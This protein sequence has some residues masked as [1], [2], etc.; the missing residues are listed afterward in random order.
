MLADEI[1]GCTGCGICVSECEFLKRHGTPLAMCRSYDPEDPKKNAICFECS[2]C[3]L[4]SAVCPEGCYPQALFL[5]MRREAV[6]RGHGVFPGHKR[7]LGYERT[8]LSRRFSWY[9]LP[10][11][12]TT[13]FFP[14]C[15]LPGTRPDATMAVYEKLKGAIPALGLVMDCCTKPSHDLGRQRYFSEMFGEMV[16]WLEANGIQ[17]ILVACPNC[18][19][20]FSEYARQFQ[21]ETIYEELAG[22]MPDSVVG[23][24]ATPVTIHDP[25]VMRFACAPQEAVRELVSGSGYVT[26][27]MPHARITTLCCGEGGTVAAL[28]P[29]LAESWGERRAGEAANRQVVT[30]CAGC[31]NFLGKRLK[32]SHVLDLICATPK[33]SSGPMT[34]FNRLR[35]KSRFRKIVPAAITRE[36]T[37]SSG[38]G[39]GVLW[40]LLILAA[41]LVILF[42]LRIMVCG[43]AEHAPK[44]PVT[45]SGK[46]K[47][48]LFAKN[49]AT[50]A[51]VTGGAGGTLIYREST[52]AFT[53]HATGL[54]PRAAYA[55]IR[56]ADAPPHGDI[57]ARGMSN[58]SG[59]LDLTGTWRN[60][61][62]K[63][64]L[65]SGEDVA[66]NAGESV[67]LRAWRPE[68]YLF[69]EKPLGIPCVCPEAE[70]PE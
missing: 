52:G 13:I 1:N 21:T 57:L 39:S 25:C 51:I 23:V 33:P 36:R 32:V 41:I 6:D 28:A 69:E 26:E 55:L 66:G 7:L 18:Y 40:P 50:W 14:G 42:L 64:W 3:G 38:T 65:V 9:G 48:R 20:V 43:A 22:M 5:E 61:T 60:W 4:C 29:A 46:K 70:E 44:Q 2:L 63:F 30:Y 54:Q 27:E 58:G 10:E 17:R 35:L 24:S 62:K 15:A 47:L 45:G 53:L 19:K 12:C 59:G 8:G 31:A 56:Y 11:G 67:S 49:P 16:A 34:Y 37:V 68:R